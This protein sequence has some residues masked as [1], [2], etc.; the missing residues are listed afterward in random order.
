[1]THYREDAHRPVG[2]AGSGALGWLFAL[3]IAAALAIGAWYVLATYGT[4]SADA[5]VQTGFLGDP[6]AQTPLERAPVA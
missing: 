5:S 6:R 3:V 4:A 1:M 2:D